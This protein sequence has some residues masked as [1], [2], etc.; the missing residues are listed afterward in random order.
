MEE[1]EKGLK[2]IENGEYDKAI[3]FFEPKAARGEY[4]ACYGLATARFKKQRVLMTREEIEEIIQLYNQSISRKPDFAD[5]HLMI[6]MAYESLA[7]TLTR[8]IN[9]TNQKPKLNETKKALEKAKEFIDE[10][11]RINPSFGKVA[12]A[13]RAACEKKISEI[14]RL[15]DE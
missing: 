6:G 13:G 1:D 14:N 9:R 15:L 5:A 11:V 12:Q 7:A 2:L 3:R 8:D 10:A 4:L